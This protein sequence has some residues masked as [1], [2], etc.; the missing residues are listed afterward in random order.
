MQVSGVTS[1][2]LDVLHRITVSLNITEVTTA[3]DSWES[4][5]SVQVDSNA[6]LFAAVAEGDLDNYTTASWVCLGVTV[7]V[8]LVLLLIA[9]KLKN[10]LAICA[11]ATQPI[12]AMPGLLLLPT[13]SVLLSAVVV[14]NFFFTICMFL[15]PDPETTSAWLLLFTSNVTNALISSAGTNVESL[16]QGNSDVQRLGSSIETLD[17]QLD[18]LPV[19][20]HLLV[21]AAAGFEAF[22]G[23]WLLCLIEAVTYTTIS[24]A[25]G[26][27]YFTGSQADRDLADPA[28][29]TR[30][31]VLSSLYRVLRYHLGTMAAGSFILAAFTAVRVVLAYIDAKTKDLQG[32]NSM[33]KYAL[34][35]TQCCLWVF[36]R[37]VKYLT[38]F[39]FVSVATD[40]MSFCSAA[41]A[42]FRLTT[43]HPLQMLA[44]E[45]AMAVLSLLQ[46]VLTP[47]MCAILAYNAVVW[48][49]RSSVL[50]AWNAANAWG[51]ATCDQYQSDAIDACGYKA[52]VIGFVSITTFAEWSADEKPNE[53]RVAVATLLVAFGVT[54][55]FRGVYA[56][57]VDTI[58]VC[59]V[60]SEEQEVA[61]PYKKPEMA[62]TVLRGSSKN[63]ISGGLI[64]T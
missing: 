58:F 16:A 42:S 31:P 57:A 55:V 53:L 45:A 13:L 49:W 52:S 48:E 61:R 29:R 26:Y 50:G 56:A 34:K 32:A 43:D 46:L 23:L 39:A 64:S 62:D 20:A 3:I 51:D 2:A 47:L 1:S 44:N 41:F 5:V 7:A 22:S 12:A 25:V 36:H 54:R 11:M 18:Q 15:T 38:K 60:R 4:G 10:A 59:C 30:F 14:I 17:V 9:S 27:W 33:L 37:I 8:V 40:G 24:G 6:D 19:D 35:C 28:D 21:Y 63:L